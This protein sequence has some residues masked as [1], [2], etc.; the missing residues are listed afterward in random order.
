MREIVYGEKKVRK[1]KLIPFPHPIH[2]P[3]LNNDFYPTIKFK[4][5]KLFIYLLGQVSQV[6]FPLDCNCSFIV[7]LKSFEPEY[8]MQVATSFLGSWV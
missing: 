3:Y 6:D 8:S 5:Q 2:F 1:V 7:W 4:M